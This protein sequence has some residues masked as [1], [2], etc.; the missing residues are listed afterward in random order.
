MT[1]L[2]DIGEHYQNEWSDIIKENLEEREDD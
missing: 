1:F 2:E